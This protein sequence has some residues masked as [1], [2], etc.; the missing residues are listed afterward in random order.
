MEIIDAALIHDPEKDEQAG[1][2]SHGQ[3]K[4]VEKTVAFVFPEVAQGDL[5]EAFEHGAV[6]LMGV[7]LSDAK[8]WRM[9]QGGARIIALF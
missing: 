3:T 2:H 4:D 9:L 7:L 6:F 8:I 5:Y 1:G